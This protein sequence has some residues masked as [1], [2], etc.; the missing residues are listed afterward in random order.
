MS[1]CAACEDSLCTSYCSCYCR[2]LSGLLLRADVK[3]GPD[4][5]YISASDLSADLTFSHHDLLLVLLKKYKYYY[6][7]YYYFFLPSV[8]KI[9]RVKSKVMLEQLE[10]V[11]RGCVGESALNGNCVVSLDC[12]LSLI[13]I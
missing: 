9:P 10:V 12:H 2:A 6:C 1:M 13:H 11:L 5:V 4:T 8:V 3:V 7:Y